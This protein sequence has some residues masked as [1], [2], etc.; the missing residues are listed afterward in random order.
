[1]NGDLAL[2]VTVGAAG[3]VDGSARV[4]RRVARRLGIGAGASNAVSAYVSGGGF[5]A[6]RAVVVARGR[7][8]AQ[9]AGTVTLKLRP[10]RAAKRAGRKLRGV[11]LAIKVSQGTARDSLSIK[12]R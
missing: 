1:M 4:P 2:R 6:A 9:R 5:A 8:T 7:K 12:L 11:R 10:T 3:R